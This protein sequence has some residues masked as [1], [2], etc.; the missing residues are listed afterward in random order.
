MTIRLQL[1]TK[2][3]EKGEMEVV[4]IDTISLSGRRW[5]IFKNMAKVGITCSTKDFCPGH[6]NDRHVQLGFHI[7]ADWFIVGWP[8]SSTVKFRSW[9]GKWKQNIKMN[10]FGWVYKTQYLL[11]QRCIATYAMV[12]SRGF[13][14]PV[15]PDQ[16]TYQYHHQSTHRA[17][18][19]KKKAIN[20]CR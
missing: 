10:L 9:S 5:S 3:F 19:R 20:Q 4:P 8:T 6:E 7:V 16:Q 13:S 14:V 11:E 18:F 1:L 2:L 17:N 15:F 12:G